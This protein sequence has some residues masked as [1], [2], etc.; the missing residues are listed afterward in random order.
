MRYY[1]LFLLSTLSLLACSS[2][3]KPEQLAPKMEL[4]SSLLVHV[5]SSYRISG[6]HFSDLAMDKKGN[7]YI[8]SFQKVTRGQDEMSIIKIAPNGSIVWNLGKGNRGRAMAITLDSEQHIWVTGFYAAPIQFGGLRLEQHPGVFIAQFNEQGQCLK[9]IDGQDA[10]PTD[11]SINAKGE[12]LL[13]GNMGSSVRIG[14]INYKR[15]ANTSSDFLAKLDTSGYCHWIKPIDAQVRRIRADQNGNFYVAGSYYERFV[16]EK[17]TLYTESDY[18]QNGF[19]LQINDSSPYWLQTFGQKGHLKNG[20]RSSE[21]ASDI[22]INRKGEVLL[23]AFQE[24]SFDLNLPSPSNTPTLDLH[25][26][27]FDSLG[28]KLEE[29]LLIEGALAKSPATIT[30][31]D[32]GQIWISGQLEDSAKIAGKQYDFPSAKQSFLLQLNK[33]SKQLKMILFPEHA[34]NMAF[35]AAASSKDYIAF[36][37]NF[38][39]FL[40]IGEQKI[41]NEG[42][43][44]LFYLV[45]FF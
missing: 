32:K 30:Q 5:Q 13:G 17:D 38:Q 41:Q 36:A 14:Q 11:I 9:L 27:V 29:S 35:R 3:Q 15:A 26:F 34:S 22:F 33:K 6:N 19:L 31:D 20:H 7:S 18:D 2:A 12:I 4:D 28:N 16:F 8:A 23:A 25:L 40:K 42:E 39:E 45:V 37:G 44:S 24:S 21:A 43:H 1:F 10:L